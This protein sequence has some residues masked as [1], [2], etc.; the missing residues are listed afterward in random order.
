MKN[1]NI[2]ELKE[3][4]VVLNESQ[5][6]SSKVNR[7]VIIREQQRVA[8]K[9]KYGNKIG[10]IHRMLYHYIKVAGIDITCIKCNGTGLVRDKVCP[11]CKGAKKMYSVDKH[12]TGLHKLYREC[13]GDEEMAKKL[14]TKVGE[15]FN[16]KGINWTI[17]TVWKDWELVNTWIRLEK[18]RKK[19]NQQIANL[20]EFN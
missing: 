19:D 2:E 7:S 18:E 10:K 9:E 3:K 6:K 13:D 11:R 1:K 15:Y 17:H 4:G 12:S 5:L 8:R 20:E 14:I 16:K